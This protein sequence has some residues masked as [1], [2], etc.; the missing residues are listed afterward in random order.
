MLFSALGRGYKPGAGREPSMKGL[1]GGTYVKVEKN[2][3]LF[4]LLLL[5]SSLVLAVFMRC[6]RQLEGESP[7]QEDR[8]DYA[9][10]HSSKQC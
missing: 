8:L 2:N 6:R 7:A 10:M 5:P 4:L 3:M 1:V 9:I